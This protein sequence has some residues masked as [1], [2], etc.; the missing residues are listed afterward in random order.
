MSTFSFVQFYDN[1]CWT[2]DSTFLLVHKIV[3]EVVLSKLILSFYGLM[4]WFL[5]LPTISIRCQASNT[6]FPPL[7][8]NQMH[9]EN[10]YRRP[11]SNH[12]LVV[13]I[14]ES[15]AAWMITHLII[16]NSVRT[17]VVAEH[18]CSLLSTGVI[19]FDRLHMNYFNFAITASLNSEHVRLHGTRLTKLLNFVFFCSLN[20]TRHWTNHQTNA[21]SSANVLA[22]LCKV[23]VQ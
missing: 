16:R 9:H 13:G 19:A 3:T 7:K 6:R 20:Q 22:T 4:V 5:S 11:L 21:K 14:G 10:F 15:L 2:Y 8:C 1:L 23:G 12:T 17:S 18:R